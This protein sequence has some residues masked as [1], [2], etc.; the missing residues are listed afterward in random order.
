[1]RGKRG[2]PLSMA[3]V[4]LGL[5]V[6][7]SHQA[8]A[9]AETTRSAD[10]WEGHVSVGPAGCDYSDLQSAIDAGAAGSHGGHIGV[11]ADY[12]MNDMYL[13]QDL[14]EW[15]DD[16]WIVG[17]FDS[18][19]IGDFD[20]AS[21]TTSLNA[22][23]QSRHFS[24][25]YEAEE[26]DPTRTVTLENFALSN[27]FAS[28]GASVHISGTPGRLTVHLR[29]TQ[30]FNNTTHVA[31]GGAINLRA[32][33]DTIVEDPGFPP[34]PVPPEIPPM[35]LLGD[36]VVIDLNTAA[37]FGGGIRCDG[38]THSISGRLMNIGN[39]QI[40]RNHAGTAGGGIDA[41]NCPFLMP[42]GGPFF[43]ALGSDAGIFLN[44]ADDR[45]GGI[46][47]SG[48]S[49]VVVN[50]TPTDIIGQPIAG[51]PDHAAVIASNEA[52][53]GGAIY[54]AGSETVV[55]IGD[56]AIVGNSAVAENGSSG[57][58]GAIYATGEAMVAFASRTENEPCSP[59]EFDGLLFVYPP[60]N[61][62]RN[63]HAEGRGGVAFV[64]NG[65]SL[66]IHDTFI[67][68]NSVDGNPR[69]GMIYAF[70]EDDEFADPPPA[71]V[72]LENTLMTGSEGGGSLL[73]AD[74]DS[75]VSVHW[76][77]IT[78][79][80]LT[81]N[82]GA[83]QAFGAADRPAHVEIVGSIVWDDDGNVALSTPSEDST[84]EAYCV[85]G[86]Q[87]P[88]SEHFDV[89]EYYSQIDPE[90]QGNHRLSFISPAIDYCNDQPVPDRDLD[91][92]ERDLL[93]D[94]DTTEPPNAHPDGIHDIGA[95]TVQEMELF[96][97][98]FEA[99]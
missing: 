21:A 72:L 74:P 19:N 58:G 91:G 70:N 82:R 36:D 7:L 35:L 13:I 4:A 33:A 23:D 39:A 49:I 63:N 8:M 61:R 68:G 17:G 62:I 46:A 55:S 30:L 45:G 79:N 10:D 5:A 48:G 40:S 60:C 3:T 64:R 12:D 44:T 51:D 95:F 59:P 28:E 15:D 53:R 86:H 56:T 34:P 73:G 67:E 11:H 52:N 88:G 83:L 27:G 94:G 65:A 2:Y 76:S 84:I 50:G 43:L 57:H 18:C 37:S 78:E 85:I 98:R 14:D 77:T 22:D 38:Q 20:S 54:A 1:M 47:A 16:P 99:D 92:R 87:D 31:G 41:H 80:D 69:G 6:G 97:D 75:E 71:T 26:E 42:S 81:G 93:F 96:H 29:D 89:T 9:G 32:T 25:T 66:F 24:I 90:I